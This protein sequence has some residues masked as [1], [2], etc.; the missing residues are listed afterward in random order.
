MRGTQYPRALIDDSGAHDRSAILGRPIKSGDDVVL[1]DVASIRI[2]PVA[3]A[4]RDLRAAELQITSTFKQPHIRIL[5]AQ[6]ARALPEEPPQSEGRWRAARRGVGSVA[7]RPSPARGAK[8]ANRASPCGAPPRR[9]LAEGP[10]FRDRASLRAFPGLYRTRPASVAAAARSSGGRRP[11]A[12]RRYRATSTPHPQAPHP[13]PRRP[14][15]RQRAPRWGGMN[16]NI[17][18]VRNVVKRQVGRD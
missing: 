2:C 13:A 16:G 18:Q 5:A 6:C 1:R 11:S 7:I 14:A 10:L 9:F 4:G 17:I 8:I 15:S 3:L 12:S